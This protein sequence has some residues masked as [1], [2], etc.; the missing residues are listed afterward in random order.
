MPFRFSRVEKAKPKAGKT[1]KGRSA[2]QDI[3][4]ALADIRTLSPADLARLATEIEALGPKYVEAYLGGAGDF[5]VTSTEAKR[6]AKRRAAKLVADITAEQRQLVRDATF[7]SVKGDMTVQGMARDERIRGLGLHSR[8][9][10]AVENLRERTAQ[11]YVKQGLTMEKAG[12]KADV[13]AE[14]YRKALVRKRARVIARTEIMSAQNAGLY[15]GIVKAIGNGTLAWDTQLEFMTAEDEK[16]C[17]IC[18]PLNGVRIGVAETFTHGLHYPPMHPNCRCTITPV[19][20]DIE[21]DPLYTPHEQYVGK[22]FDPSEARDADG[23]WT[24]G[25]GTWAKHTPPKY[26]VENVSDYSRN[27]NESDRD[28]VREYAQDGTFTAFNSTLR[29]EEPDPR[30]TDALAGLDGSPESKAWMQNRMSELDHAIGN[31]GTDYGLSVFRGIHG[32]HLAH[33]KTGDTFHE[34]GYVSTTTHPQIAADFA[35]ENGPKGTIMRIDLPGG[36]H[37]VHVDAIP[38][39]TLGQHE[40]LLPRGQTFRVKGVKTYEDGLRVIHVEPTVRKALVLKFNPQEARDSHGRWTGGAGGGMPHSMKDM[41]AIPL[42]NANGEADAALTS[43]WEENL[44]GEYGKSGVHVEDVEA[45]FDGDLLNLRGNFIDR[46]GMLSGHFE[47]SIWPNEASH[48]LLT[49]DAEHQGKGIATDFNGRMEDW[50]AHNGISQVKV[51]AAMQN[52]GYT[53]ARAGYDWEKPQA[54]KFH[55]DFFTDM[56]QHMLDTAKVYRAKG[57]TAT[58]DRL[59]AIQTQFVLGVASGDYSKMP[60]PWEL[61]NMKASDGTPIGKTLL[62]GTN[63]H[64]VKQL[65]LAKAAALP[66]AAA[67][68]KFVQDRRLDVDDTYWSE[69]DH[70]AW[71]A[72]YAAMQPT[73]KALVLKFNPSQPRD[74]DGR[75]TAGPG[76]LGAFTPPL[77]EDVNAEHVAFA[78]G[79]EGGPVPAWKAGYYINDPNYRGGTRREIIRRSLDKAWGESEPQPIVDEMQKQVDGGTVTIRASEAGATGILMDGEFKAQHETGS[80]NGFLDPEMR[81]AAED[82]MFGG[83][84]N[85]EHPIYGYIAGGGAPEPTNYGQVRFV[86]NEAAKHRTTV[87]LGDTLNAEATLPS[88]ATKVDKYAINPEVQHVRRHYV[89]RIKALRSPKSKQEAARY[90]VERM[91]DQQYIETQT[92]GGVNAADISEV[93]LPNYGRESEEMR[94]I[95]RLAGVWGI[96]VRWQ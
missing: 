31:S 34:P 25:L 93:I 75:W 59:Q 87:S 29:G 77:G 37:V 65:R 83:P 45:Y 40:M 69:Q 46:E 10:R 15:D 4:A 82:T 24:G 18:G 3:Y 60:H 21:N 16:V 32:D 33:L 2:E 53:W 80:S 73:A 28:V 7:E 71:D 35:R 84:V 94:N 76:G 27:L 41:H 42:D 30:F 54:G 85:G 81:L 49:I 43:M 61:A 8:W 88:P 36:S 11:Q 64:G 38:E 50:Y 74:H 58:A 1:G 63:W 92:H 5:A 19:P 39:A 20:A 48:D 90:A 6:Y 47:R 86:L 91:R 56:R 89:E 9:A 14:R 17:P 79:P 57:D 66:Y 67:F 52:G 13:V 95:E 44:Q 62:V 51:H 23:K 12:E 70:A 26:A 78:E 68:D 96:P 22:A 72:I 55:P